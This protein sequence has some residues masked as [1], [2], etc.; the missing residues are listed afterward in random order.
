M[1]NAV[2]RISEVSSLMRKRN[3]EGECIIGSAREMQMALLDAGIEV[4]RAIVTEDMRAVGARYLARP[5][6]ADLSEHHIEKG[7]HEVRKGLVTTLLAADPNTIIFTDD[8]L[9]DCCDTKLRQWV[10]E[11]E[12]PKPRVSAFRQGYVGVACFG[13][14]FSEMDMSGKVFMQDGAPAHT[15]KNTKKNLEE[16]GVSV[17][18]WPPKS[19]DLNPIENLWG[20]VK[21]RMTV[22]LKFTVTHHRGTS[23]P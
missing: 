15:A 16:K 10:V 3:R 9:F 14:F 18:K 2:H 1:V 23:M 22:K 7:R 4:S 19:P 17:L 8:S 5:N 13:I 12:K 20:I 11:G 6:T 21:S